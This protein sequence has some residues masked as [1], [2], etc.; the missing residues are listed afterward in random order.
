MSCCDDIDGATLVYQPLL[1]VITVPSWRRGL[2]PQVTGIA[3]QTEVMT[4][5]KPGIIV[6]TWATR[7]IELSS[8]HEFRSETSIYIM[9]LLWVDA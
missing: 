5:V 8:L 4:I 1:L 2:I 6:S 7:F 9:I 3:I